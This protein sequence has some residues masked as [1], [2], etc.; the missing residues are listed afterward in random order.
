MTQPLRQLPGLQP[1]APERKA[2]HRAPVPLLRS[3]DLRSALMLVGL[4]A[5]W[6]F[7]RPWN[8][9][10]HDGR[11]YAVQALHWL[12][13]LQYSRDL[14]FLYGSQDA[15]TLFSP[16]YAGF[17]KFLGL[18]AGTCLLHALGAAL[19]L[20]AAAFLLSGF[21]RG[22]W[23]WLCLAAVLLLP[24]DYDPVRAFGLAEPFLTPRIFGEAFGML[25]I[26]WLLRGRRLLAFA[27][28]AL[29]F[30]LHPLM[31][32]GVA[33]F[34]FCYLA[35]NLSR[36]EQ[37][38]VAALALSLAGVA[39]LGLAPFDR[40]LHTMDQE[41]YRHVERIIPIVAWDSWQFE[42]TASRVTVAFSLVLAAGCLSAGWRARF[43]W[44]SALAGAAGLLASWLGTSI[45]HN[46]LM[47]QLQPWRSLWLTQ[48]ASVVALAWLAAA[49]WQ[50]GRVYRV[51]LLTLGVAYLARDSYGGLLAI[52]GALGLCWQAR[53]GTQLELPNRTYGLLLLVVAV[54]A[55]GWVANAD[56][57][58]IK[59]GLVRPWNYADPESL[60]SMRGWALLRLGGAA[61]LGVALLQG[62][63]YFAGLRR[64]QAVLAAAVLALGGL[65][66]ALYLNNDY[67]AAQARMSPAARQGLKATFQPL[68]A[69]QATVYWH[70]APERAWFVLERSGYA[71]RMQV[72]GMV[73]NR[74][75]ALEGMRRLTRLQQLG[76]AESLFGLKQDAYALL[77]DSLPSQPSVAGL[78]SVCADP[79]LDFVVLDQGFGAGQVAKVA[80]PAFGTSYYLYD[81]K[82][83]RGQLD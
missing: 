16:L 76:N 52:G 71:S 58:T 21:R 25:A 5:L 42:R 26:A 79:A 22:V 70:D 50:R 43:Y 20:A 54:L 45:F 75:T 47:L 7:A 24:G 67:R 64:V 40:L 27:A 6:L 14:F 69:P 33:V 65:G 51:L 60:A 35:P 34:G 37:L 1:A 10:W 53:R 4:L 28:F 55:T 66:G 62:I 68:I 73:F 77:A 41:W 56:S 80:D 61:A 13:P 39:V 23:P 59:P 72:F 3:W 48:L 17:V 32:M 57:E 31:L 83:L 8:G 12:N 44:C 15:F 78:R 49:F 19:W 46:L 63:W 29:G 82:R 74:G 36:R 81:C 18:E 9:L 11:L 2:A 30:T 38:A